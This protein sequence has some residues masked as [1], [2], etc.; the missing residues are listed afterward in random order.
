MG[1]ERRWLA[2]AVLAMGT[3]ALYKRVVRPWMY[4][5]GAY[6]DEVHAALPGDELVTATT[7]RSTRGVTIE[8]PVEAVWPWLAQIGEDRGGFYSYDWL[9]RSVGA[10]THDTNTIH[11]EWQELQVGD[12]VWLVRRYGPMAR[13]VVAAVAPKSHLVLMSE[14]DFDRLSRGE[15]ARGSWAFY[16]VPEGPRTRLLAR[17]S[18]GAVG[19]ATFDI[20][21][22]VMEQKMLRGIR[23]R[24]QTAND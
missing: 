13:Q 4:T 9:E 21:Q 3:E 14:P 24:A 15:R 19:V 16:L 6:P 10:E 7:P 22:F 1:N 2:G 23:D 17:G 20:P 8:A 5:W 11:P 18:G 12:P